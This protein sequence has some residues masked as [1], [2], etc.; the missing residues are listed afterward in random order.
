MDYNRRTEERDTG[1][2]GEVDWAGGGGFTEGN[3]GKT[4][5]KIEN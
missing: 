3:G 4:E 1:G 2:G 5:L